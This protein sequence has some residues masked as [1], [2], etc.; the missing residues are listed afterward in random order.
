MNKLNTARP[1]FAVIQGKGYGQM[2]DAELIMLCQ[3]YQDE[4]AFEQLVRRYQR[5]VYGLLY[6]LAPDWPDIADLAQE[7]FI[8]MWRGIDKLQNAKAFKQWLSQIVTNL[9]YDELR[10]RPRRTQI[11]SL[12]APINDDE[13]SASRDIPDPAAGPDDLVHRK[14]VQTLVENAIAELPKQFRTAII[15]REMQDLPYDEIARITNTD[16]GTV[17]SRIARARAKIQTRLRP[18]LDESDRR[19]SA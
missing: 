15:L 18:V 3:Q 13:E 7:A 2:E 19:L 6:K 5:T 12:D 11:L 17:K 4:A 10:K 1:R 14:D 16:L 9:F 8:R